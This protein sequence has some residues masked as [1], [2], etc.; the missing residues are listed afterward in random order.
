MVW[1]LKDAIWHRL[2]FGAVNDIKD[3][4]VEQVSPR[5]SKRK[6]SPNRI[7]SGKNLFG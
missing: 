6:C 3:L 4:V 7:A 2:L 1:L 5:H